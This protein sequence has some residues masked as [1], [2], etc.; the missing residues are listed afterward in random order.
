LRPTR[1]E[2]TDVANAIID[3]SDFLMLSAETA[4]GKHPLEAVKMMNQII[5]FTESQK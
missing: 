4:A 3:G 1:A 2:V 5:K